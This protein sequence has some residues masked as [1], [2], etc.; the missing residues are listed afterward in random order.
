MTAFCDDHPK[1]IRKYHLTQSSNWLLQT[2]TNS[3]CSSATVKWLVSWGLARLSPQVMAASPARNRE[4]LKKAKEGQ[5]MRAQKRWRGW[6]SETWDHCSLGGVFS[7]KW[8]G[9]GINRQGLLGI[10]KNG[11]CRVDDDEPTG[12]HQMWSQWTKMWMYHD[13]TLIIYY[14]QREMS[15]TQCSHWNQNDRFQVGF[16]M[17]W[18]N[19]SCCG[20]I[21]SYAGQKTRC[22]NLII[23]ILYLSSSQVRHEYSLFINIHSYSSLVLIF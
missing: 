22:Q 18:E 3:K 4:G 15:K 8:T 13:V 9:D 16:F 6:T 20:C 12:I 21:L 7:K 14:S 17:V 10:F 5:V 19:N 11:D 2:F 1:C 23:Y